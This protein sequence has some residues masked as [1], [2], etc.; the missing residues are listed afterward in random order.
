MKFELEFKL[1]RALTMLLVVAAIDVDIDEGDAGR[2]TL[3]EP[4]GVT[5]GDSFNVVAPFDR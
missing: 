4:F 2:D 1:E 3:G 5:F